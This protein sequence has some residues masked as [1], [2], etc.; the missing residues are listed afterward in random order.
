MCQIR[1][2]TPPDDIRT[3]IKKSLNRKNYWNLDVPA[4][5]IRCI[6]NIIPVSLPWNNFDCHIYFRPVIRLFSIAVYQCLIR[7]GWC[8]HP[9]RTYDVGAPSAITISLPGSD[10]ADAER[11]RWVYQTGY[12][13]CQSYEYCFRYCLLFGSFQVCSNKI[14]PESDAS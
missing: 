8:Q 13:Y 9:V 11:R 6:F 5:V 7:I 12:F 10:P 14:F 4:V 2:V 1:L 3:G